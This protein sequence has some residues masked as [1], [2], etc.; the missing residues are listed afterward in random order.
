[1]GT[2]RRATSKQAGPS[3]P[4]MV[5]TLALLLATTTPTNVIAPLQKAMGGLV[6]IYKLYPPRKV[7]TLLWLSRRTSRQ[8]KRRSLNR[9]RHLLG[10]RLAVGPSSRHNKT[11]LTHLLGR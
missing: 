9:L 8:R 2:S 3:T 5:E 10:I 4:L 6:S 7:P 11:W 1:M